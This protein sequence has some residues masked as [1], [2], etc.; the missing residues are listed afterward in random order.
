MTCNSLTSQDSNRL[1]FPPQQQILTLNHKYL[2]LIKN[3]KVLQ[4]ICLN[5]DVSNSAFVKS[6]RFFTVFSERMYI[7][8]C[9]KTICNPRGIFPQNLSSIDAAVSEDSEKKQTNRHTYYCFRGRIWIQGISQKLCK[10]VRERLGFIVST[11]L[12][13]IAKITNGCIYL[14]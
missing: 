8:F 2:S 13:K 3:T 9:L 4:K 10:Q 7:V 14:Q 11:K 6:K 1:P 5:I 12:A